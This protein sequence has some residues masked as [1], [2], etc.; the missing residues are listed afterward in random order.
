MSGDFFVCRSLFA[1]KENMKNQL[2]FAAAILLLSL[3]L[4]ACKFTSG[5]KET[6]LKSES[7]NAAKAPTS[8]VERADNS[9]RKAV[10]RESDD[11]S[12]SS[13]D[14]TDLQT[15][16]TEQQADENKFVI[17]RSY[18]AADPNRPADMLYRDGDYLYFQEL[19]S[20][21]TA[22]FYYATKPEEA[23]YVLWGGEVIAGP[24]TT[25]AQ[26]EEVTAKLSR[27]MQYEHEIRMS[28]INN[29]PT[30]GNVRTRV[31]DENGN[32]I[33]EY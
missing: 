32:L 29:Y 10:N 18:Y 26:V 11:D 25:K 27:D 33:T 8:K 3:S 23:I 31:Y 4:L 14:A 19:S 22:G 12:V 15:N 5:S 28:I 9:S 30:G 24:L 7:S 16:N 1:A 17:K 2:T 13:E 21:G 6:A 20:G